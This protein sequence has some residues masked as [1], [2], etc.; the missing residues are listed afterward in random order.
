MDTIFYE[1]GL[2]ILAFFIWKSNLSIKWKKVIVGLLV[3]A[4][5]LNLVPLITG[6]KILP[7]LF[8]R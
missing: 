1:L 8:G 6:K 5:I 7:L 2:I 4:I 3:I